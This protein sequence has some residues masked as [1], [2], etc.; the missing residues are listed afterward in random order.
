M[1][2][3]Q[4]LVIAENAVT[5]ATTKQLSLVNII[6]EINTPGVPVIFPVLRI[7]TVWTRENITSSED[8]N[9]RIQIEYPNGERFD[10]DFEFNGQIPE[11]KRR[12]RTTAI[13]QGIPLRELGV[14]NF[15]VEKRNGTE[16]D[17]VG[18][19]PVEV[20]QILS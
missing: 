13:I 8:I 11:E 18:R 5:D 20:K 15:I 19:Y 6:E 10:Q 4:L 9:F 12:L 3:L 16:W 14:I 2:T 1:L 17:E 7:V